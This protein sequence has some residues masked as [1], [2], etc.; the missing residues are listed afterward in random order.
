M[1]FYSLYYLSP[2]APKQVAKRPRPWAWMATKGQKFLV[3]WVAGGSTANA[4]Q[5][6]IQSHSSRVQQHR[7]TPRRAHVYVHTH[8]HTHVQGHTQTQ[9]YTHS[10]ITPPLGITSTAQHTWAPGAE[11]PGRLT[12]IQGSDD[13][14]WHICAKCLLGPISFFR[15]QDQPPIDLSFDKLLLS[16]WSVWGVPWVLRL[17]LQ[18]KTMF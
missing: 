5:W 12:G 6:L 17:Q 1:W 7:I 8:T 9:K 2:Q 15:W 18:N 14:W 3:V 10:K 11:A 16:T 13:C 4:K